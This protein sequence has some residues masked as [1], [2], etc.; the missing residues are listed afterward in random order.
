MKKTKVNFKSDKSESVKEQQLQKEMK[1]VGKTAMA[2]VV[3]VGIGCFIAGWL[4]GVNSQ[5]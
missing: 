2:T 3:I 5:E 4:G 1:F